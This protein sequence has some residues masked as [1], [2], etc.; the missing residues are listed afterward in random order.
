MSIT[1]STVEDS[2]SREMRLKIKSEV[3]ETLAAMQQNRAKRMS[4]QDLAW[5][6]LVPVW[7]LPIADKAEFKGGGKAL[8][9]FLKHAEELGLVAQQLPGELLSSRVAEALQRNADHQFWMPETE[10]SRVLTD[11]RDRIGPTALLGHVRAICTRLPPKISVPALDQWR[12]LATLTVKDSVGL[13]AEELLGVVRELLEDNQSGAALGRLR[14]GS[15]LAQALG[16]QLESAVMRGRR[17]V[18]V[19]Y[20]RAHDRRALAG[21][22]EREEQSLAFAELM[23]GPDDLWALHFLGMGGVGKTMLIRHINAELAAKHDRITARVDFDYISPNYPLVRPE[24]LLVELAD[25]LRAQSDPE[26]F[27]QFEHR[28]R[29][30]QDVMS[31]RSRDE[32][33]SDPLETSEF[34]SVQRSFSDWLAKLPRKVVLILDTCEE[35][36]KLQPGGQM[37]PSIRATYRIL[38]DLHR[39]NPSLRVIFAGRRPLALS[40]HGWRLRTEG[41]PEGRRHLPEK[42]YLRLHLI[43]GFTGPETDEYFRRQGVSISGELRDAILENSRESPAI[44][45]L[46]EGVEVGEDSR[47]NPFDLSLYV[48]WLRET[49]DLTAKLIRSGRTD[50]YIDLRIARRLTDSVRELLPAVAFLG[51]FDEAMLRPAAPLVSDTVFADIFREL[52]EQEWIDYQHDDAGSFLQVDRNLHPRLLG[53]FAATL[54]QHRLFDHARQQLAPGLAQLV[55]QRLPSIQPRM[56]AGA[57]PK[58]ELGFELVH[59]A[60][61]ALDAAAAS[62]LWEEIETHVIATGRWDWANTITGRLLGEQ[63]AGEIDERLRPAVMATQSSAMLHMDS[64]SAVAKAW[65]NVIALADRAYPAERAQAIAKRAWLGKI[66]AS[67][68]EVIMPEDVKRLAQLWEE[69]HNLPDAFRHQLLYLCRARCAR[70]SEAR[71]APPAPAARLSPLAAHIFANVPLSASDAYGFEQVVAALYA[72]MEKVIDMIESGKQPPLTIQS[73][74]TLPGRSISPELRAFGFTLCSRLHRHEGRRAQAEETVRAAVELAR[75]DQ[76]QTP[77]SWAGWVAPDSIEDFAQL[78]ELLHFRWFAETAASA[79]L[80]TRFPPVHGL[81]SLDTERLVSLHLELLLGK[82]L[83]NLHTLEELQVVDRY[84]GPRANERAAHRAV[85]P[86]VVN[87]AFG[88]LARGDS[89]RALALLDT[90]IQGAKTAGPD[91]QMILQCEQAKLRVITRM[92]LQRRGETLMTRSLQTP[93][94]APLGWPARALNG[95]PSPELPALAAVGKDSYFKIGWIWP[96]STNTAE[97]GPTPRALIHAW[98]RSRTANDL[99]SGRAISKAAKAVFERAQT[100]DDFSAVVML[101]DYRESELCNKDTEFLGTF[102]QAPRIGGVQYP[103]LKEAIDK[104]RAESAAP[105]REL[106][107]LTLRLNALGIDRTLWGRELVGRR[108]LAELALEEGELL[109][110]RLPDLAMDLLELAYDEFVAVEDWVGALVAGICGEIAARR[111]GMNMSSSHLR[112]RAKVPLA[113][114]HVLAAGASEL[115]SWQKLESLAEGQDTDLSCLD[116]S[117]WGGWLHRLF[118]CLLARR[119]GKKNTAIVWLARH[120]GEH[121]PEEL[122]FSEEEKRIARKGQHAARSEDRVIKA[123][124]SS[125]FVLFVASVVALVKSA[126]GFV[127]TLISFAIFYLGLMIAIAAKLIDVWGAARRHFA[128][129]IEPMGGQASGDLAARLPCQ[130]RVLVSNP[131]GQIDFDESIVRVA[132]ST[133]GLERYQQAASDFPF[134]VVDLLVRTRGRL[135]GNSWWNRLAI[136]F[137][138]SPQLS[139]EPWEALTAFALPAAPKSWMVR[140]WDTAARTILMVISGAML[141][142]GIIFL[143]YDPLKG[144]GIAPAVVVGVIT[145]LLLIASWRSRGHELHFYRGGSRR[146]ST[147][148]RAEAWM[149]RQVECNCS[150]KWQLL[151]EQGL[152]PLKKKHFSVTDQ[153]DVRRNVINRTLEGG[154]NLTG[155]PHSLLLAVGRAVSST[156]GFQ[157]EIEDDKTL[158]EPSSESVEDGRTV[159]GAEELRGRQA[160]LTII[161]GEPLTERSTRGQSDRESAALLR[162]LGAELFAAG[163]EAVLVLP[164]LHAPMA[165]AALRIIAQTLA[166]SRPPSLHRMLDAVARVRKKISD[167]P[168]PPLASAGSAPNP[169]DA[170]WFRNDQLELAF[171]ICLFARDDFS[172]P[173]SETTPKA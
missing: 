41:L 82:R 112:L 38:E 140:F 51:R 29:S 151:V 164:S 157:L 142:F 54:E 85:A 59:A 16:G 114:E 96:I 46:I 79:V 132:I 7:T 28:V 94:L 15:L 90:R 58:L 89:E 47:S 62:D 143:A 91:P 146:W 117:A 152:A 125:T 49:P 86:L 138:V 21:F 12:E 170:E 124:I 148:Q 149:T 23:D 6:A 84:T 37:A 160:V 22:L 95:L 48:Q 171:D 81:Q 66:A 156:A 168:E 165:E 167:W 154:I 1:A 141:V 108:R 99:Q 134:E 163:A 18:E 40:G 2:A 147:G 123:A 42:N 119:A 162:A 121:L 150:R 68:H 126:F 11:L 39:A 102:E 145:T 36:A 30:L 53:Y 64:G 43:R 87:L 10:R 4:D 19:A 128:L 98:W 83:I 109:G 80:E 107:R 31:L 113:Y 60:L 166:S 69:L 57:A 24:Q 9:E 92:R 131:K 20:R 110:L 35:L 101:A 74:A 144:L 127:L 139:A 169:R 130:L 103:T 78:E 106:V 33:M 76:D 65:E 153:S 120:Y 116:H 93:E 55:H 129:I 158:L 72:A 32:G 111:G 100:G 105:S 173:L 88:W 25:E 70:L 17:E 52:A 73:P 34:Q 137:L 5:L 63:D 61:R 135:L 45:D 155:L 67:R 71:V 77:Q 44:V 3:A 75:T 161:Q 104:L 133:P 27:A 172:L 26:D 115:P 13:A 159:L 50:P 56:I 97:E 136:P 14:T 8:R 118:R 122:G